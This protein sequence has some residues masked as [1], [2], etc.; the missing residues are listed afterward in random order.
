MRKM[1]RVALYS[2]VALSVL[3]LAAPL[4][5]A[6]TVVN[7][8]ADND[9]PVSNPP[10]VP[11]GTNTVN[12]G[13][14][15]LGVGASVSVGATGAAVSTSVTGIG[16]HFVN[17]IGGFGTVTQSATNDT[18]A[19][20]TNN[21]A[22]LN[23]G[24]TADSGSSL[25]IGARGASAA[26]SII[27]IG[28]LPFQPVP[29]VGDI[30][31][32]LV[33]GPG[34]PPVVNGA[35]VVN[36]GEITAPAAGTP[37]D[38]TGAGASASVSATG[39]QS[40]VALSVS[41]ATAFG[42]TS[43]GAINQA[44]FNTPGASIFNNV[45]NN[46][47]T[48][49]ALSGDGTSVSSSANGALASVSL[50]YINT[51]NWSPTSITNVFQNPQNSGN[52]SNLHNGGSPITVGAVSGDGASVRASAGGAVAGL[53]YSTIGSTVAAGG[54][55]NLGGVGQLAS[56]GANVINDARLVV[57]G[58]TGAGS[59]AVISSI[60]A[61]AS[62]SVSSI[63]D[64]T[65]PPFTQPGGMT[66]IQVTQ[67]VINIGSF[68]SNFAGITMSGALGNGAAASLS[69]TGAQ[70]SVS[71]SSINTASYTTPF[72]GGILQTVSN[73]NPGSPANV[74]NNVAGLTTGALSGHGASVSASATGAAASIGASFINTTAYT[75]LGLQGAGQ[76]VTNNGAITNSGV[77]GSPINV[78]NISGHGASVRSSATGA[79]AS[80]SVSSIL[81]GPPTPQIFGTTGVAQTVTNAGAIQNTA[82]S[83]IAGSISGT[84]ASASIGATG[85]AASVAVASIADT[86][87]IPPPLAVIGTISQTVTNNVGS[88]ITNAGSITLTGGAVGTAASVSIAAVGAS[89]SVSFLAVR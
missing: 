10:L 78:G 56:N 22:I 60:G 75:S 40:S 31:Q 57:G 23:A 9:S 63:G 37:M 1:Y 3:V 53:S 18:A 45:T 5:H 68:V 50:S 6:Q 42:S 85:A 86:A 30:A 47:V 44:P 39:A 52:V 2:G 43:F 34:T 79:V 83:I 80:V 48:L 8:T 77:A 71:V 27:A 87:V 59:S 25:S 69:A 67:Q 46:G 65:T 89:A 88:S 54:G 74:T 58:L 66:G 28:G 38:L 41:G 7:Q 21:G 13:G 36:T 72:L 35:L 61:G 17:P 24:G 82:A 19:P 81:S 51:T 15:G 73:G 55:Q 76:N 32:G 70:A 64:T 49:G 11:G 16:A 4:A 33:V 29:I 20:I 26:F 62:F 84:A 12:M 14:G